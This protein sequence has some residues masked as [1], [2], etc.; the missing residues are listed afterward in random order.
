MLSEEEINKL[1]KICLS[2]YVKCDDFLDELVEYFTKLI[3][4]AVNIDIDDEIPMET[5]K[6]AI[7]EGN[8]EREL[9]SFFFIYF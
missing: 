9:L 2:K 8:Q 7:L 4:S 1:C 6:K 3:F 5:I